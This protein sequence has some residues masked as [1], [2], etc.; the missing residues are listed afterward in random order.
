MSQ[1]PPP[2]LVRLRE[3]DVVR[4]C[5]L[6]AAAQGIELAARHAITHARR[7]Q[8]RLSAT[9]TQDGILAAV[10]ADFSG[11]TVRWGCNGHALDAPASGPDAPGDLSGGAMPTLG[12][13]HV[14]ALL[15]VWLRQPAEFAAPA[16][17][18]PRLEVAAAETLPMRGGQA[19]A[20]HAA[21]ASSPTQMTQ[22]RLLRPPGRPRS[23]PALA[24][25]LARL[26]ATELAGIARRVLQAD[27][28]PP[29]HEAREQVAAALQS[30]AIVAQL[31][32][33]LDSAARGL[34]AD[35]A[36]LGGAITAAD[37]DAMAA[38]SGRA[39][40]A[41]RAE[42]AVL[43]RHGLVF[44]APAVGRSDA[45]GDGGH[46][47]RSWRAVAGWRIP[48]ELRGALASALSIAPAA[49]RAEYGPPLL[50]P[51]PTVSG[52]LVTST[53][54]NAAA[55]RTARV[56]HATPRRLALALALL[57]HAPSPYN[58]L[59]PSPS[60]ASTSS[61]TSTG[62]TAAGVGRAPFPLVAGDLPPR[63]LTELA[64]GLGVPSGLAQLARRVLLWSRDGTG[65]YPLLDLVRVPAEERPRVLRAAFRLWR[66]AEQ[67]AELA[68]LALPGSPVVVA[69][70]AHHPA[71]R[72]AAL[73]AEALAA[74]AFLL[75]LCASAEPG[76]W[77]RL[78]DLLDLVWRVYP[79]FLRG[80]QSAHAAP[81][82]WLRTPRDARPMRASV[83]EEWL[84]AEGAFIRTFCEGPLVWWGMLDCAYT[85]DGPLYAVRVTALGRYLLGLGETPPAD[86][87]A[88]LA[89]ADA[90]A[91]VLP[92]REGALAVQP[93]AAGPALLDALDGWAH[94][95]A[96]AGGRL[97]YAP[98][99]GLA[100]V[101]FDRDLSPEPLLAQLRALDA[102]HGTR[103]AAALA[104]RLEA[105]RA[106]YGASRIE[107]GWA[108]L[109][110]R[111]EPA[112]VEALAVLP[113]LSERCR[114]LAPAI[115]LIPLADAPAL[116]AAL[117]KRGYPL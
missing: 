58:P 105:W 29:E 15:S 114:R 73:A 96:L 95:T 76:A 49:T 23:A 40:G 97:V 61:H 17:L 99:A 75:S 27:P 36:L 13:A 25:E 52:A 31:L 79:L 35:L 63:A 11:E 108:L 89:A 20:P 87:T 41:L 48:A 37:L 4:L 81:A 62:A 69:F 71:L 112:L 32:A 9:V 84:V 88:T 43:A 64:R 109:E 51:P 21:P 6:E 106:E 103:T 55:L 59:I 1:S 60:A 16:S 19:E 30:W 80:R 93:L 28:P 116:G 100:C 33:R 24:D 113:A 67:P 102:R 86:V 26:P 82:W 2:L 18:A 74:R 90:S 101:A 22:P 110:A 45:D 12:C 54:T 104:P 94:V 39:P 72:P 70:D 85:R 66:A 42:I 117:A 34:L 47:G 38:R 68:D 44:A 50:D 8:G 92:T 83:H 53:N 98:S 78:A 3:A 77:Y 56:L 46:A 5:G 115:A 57:P 107:R 91:P 65:E 111:D 7:E 14:A 10:W